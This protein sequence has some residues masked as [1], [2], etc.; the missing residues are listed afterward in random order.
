MVCVLQ[1]AAWAYVTPCE[2]CVGVKMASEL[3]PAHVPLQSILA[4]RD[5]CVFVRG[6]PGSAS[7]QVPLCFACKAF[8]A[9]GWVEAH[10]FVVCVP[11]CML[12]VTF[13]P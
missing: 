11:C 9:G 8:L 12:G 6:G 2:V 4:T 7:A 1:H 10:T 13:P 3:A 5:E